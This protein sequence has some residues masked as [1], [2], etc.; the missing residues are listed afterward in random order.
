MKIL[1]IV[2]DF[3]PPWEGLAPGP[4]ELSQAQIELGNEVTVICGLWPKQ[5]PLQVPYLG[6][7]KLRR[8][9]REP[10]RGC[11]FFT[12]AIFAF[13]A[14]FSLRI[15]NRLAP[16]RKVLG[17]DLIH[18]H[19]HLPF[20]LHIY[21]KLFGRI[22]KTPYF[23]HLHITAAGRER[24][25]KEADDK[26]DFLTRFFEW[27]LHK[28][29][30]KLGCQVAEAIFTVSESVKNEAIKYYGADPLKI[31]VVE[32]GVNC[33]MF[34]PTRLEDQDTHSFERM[35][36]EIQPQQLNIK[37]KIILFLGRHT[38]RKNLDNLILSLKSLPNEF[39]LLT[40]GRGPKT[41]LEHL[42]RLVK[43]EAL[44]ERVIFAGFIPYPE[45]PAIYQN[46]DIFVLP[47]SYE[48]FPKVVLEALASGVPVLVSGFK[49]EKKIAGLNFLK[50]TKPKL[51][52]QE[53]QRIVD[54]DQKVN[55]ELIEKEYSW[56][57][58]AQ[59]IQNV[60]KKLI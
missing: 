52:A 7:M 46:A 35:I 42:K 38:D 21:K 12:T 18:G 28:L 8:F 9:M 30:D 14:I 6:R 51:L 19:G 37:D 10:F 22:D 23:F 2:Y 17:F 39:K 41:Y 3:P 13:I 45:T 15:I 36:K 48:G 25:A 11:L 60:Y 29:S 27:P 20:Y 59:K 5:K 56:K 16:N 54:E 55:V 43:K 33:S 44:K 24:K 26:I 50:S 4:Y 1:R 31:F 57:A 32:N 49:F 47:S 40:V 34:Q 58:K 53:I